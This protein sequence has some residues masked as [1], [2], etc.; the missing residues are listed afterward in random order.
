MTAMQ[1]KVESRQD[2]DDD[3]MNNPIK[4]LNAIKE[5]ALNYQDKKY[6]MLIIMDAFRAYAPT[7]QKEGESLQDF[8]KGFKVAKDGLETHLG[9]PIILTTF[10][11]KMSGYLSESENNYPELANTAFEQYSAYSYLARECMELY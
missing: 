5:H 2:C 4:L 1:H 3:F 10:M 7:K 11:T 6:L 9:S 8:T